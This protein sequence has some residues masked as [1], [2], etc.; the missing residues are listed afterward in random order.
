MKSPERSLSL[1][2]G[3]GLMGMGQLWGRREIGQHTVMGCT[4]TLQRS[5]GALDKPRSGQ[6]PGRC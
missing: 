6:E 2:Q 5:S 3:E 1:Q 4:P